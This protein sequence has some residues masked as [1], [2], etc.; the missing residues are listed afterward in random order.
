MANRHSTLALFIVT[1]LRVLGRHAS[2]NVRKVLWTL[3]EVDRAY[4]FEVWEAAP[5]PDRTSELHALNPN[6]Q[7]PILVGAS[8]PLWESNTICRYLVGAAG[9]GDL[10]PTD[11]RARAD[12]ECWM[13]WQATDLNAAWHYAFLALQRRKPG[14]TD[15]NSI[16]ASVDVWNAKMAIL[17]AQL[18]RTGEFAVGSSFTLAD[19]FLG[20]SVHRW[21]GT[22]MDRPDLP[23]VAA[24][25]G[26]LRGRPHFRT[27]ASDAL[28]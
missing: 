11:H 20:L 9:R 2:I 14:F 17:D 27:H 10:L 13:D 24:Y 1:I 15:S 8:A 6:A 7:F 4:R 16:R 18:D 19:I 12:V 21:L 3:D 22:P 26:R 5:S 23:N 25:Y 28:I